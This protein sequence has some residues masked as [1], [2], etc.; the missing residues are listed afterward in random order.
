MNAKLYAHFGLLTFMQL[1][2]GD[3]VSLLPAIPSDIPKHA[4]V[5]T[6]SG[7]IGVNP[8]ES[9]LGNPTTYVGQIYGTDTQYITQTSSTTKVRFPS[10]PSWFSK[11]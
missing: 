3:T 10:T 11:N 9:D 7:Q 6:A 8:V 4:I 2:S 1:A 5:P